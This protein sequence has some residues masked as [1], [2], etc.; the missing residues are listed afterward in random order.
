MKGVKGGS[1][2]K[3]IWD[4]TLRG[5]AGSVAGMPIPLIHKQGIGLSM[6]VYFCLA[7]LESIS[8]RV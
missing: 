6:F 8:S 4:P 5:G 3:I 7:Y 2:N 1:R